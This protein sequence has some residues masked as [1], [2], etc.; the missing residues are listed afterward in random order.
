VAIADNDVYCEPCGAE[1]HT[2]ATT[3][4]KGF[5]TFRGVWTNA[6][7]FPIAVSIPAPH[8]VVISEALRILEVFLMGIAHRSAS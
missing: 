6:A 7:S 1:T 2:W 8:D 4:A 3:D 5:Y